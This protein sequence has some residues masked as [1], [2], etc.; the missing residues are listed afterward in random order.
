MHLLPILEVMIRGNMFKA[1]V[2]TGCMTKKWKVTSSVWAINGREI[3]CKGYSNME[4]AV[5][6]TTLRL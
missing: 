6:G 2:D 3:D 4:I 1:L 5:Q